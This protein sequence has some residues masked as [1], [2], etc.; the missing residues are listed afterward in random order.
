MMLRPAGVLIISLLFLVTGQFSGSA[1]SAAIDVGNWQAYKAKFI[2]A[3]GRV[4]DDGNHNIS[5][6]EGQGYGLLL[7]YLADQPADFDAIWSFTRTELLIRDD[8]LAAWHWDPSATPHVTDINNAT[9]GDI[10]IAYALTLAGRQWKRDDLTQ[11]ARTIAQSLLDKAIVEHEGRALLLPGVTGF[12]ADDRKDGPVVNPSYCVFEAFPVLNEL[13]PSPKW[14]A[15]S[16][17]CLALLKEMQFGPKQLPAE[18]VSLRDK[19]AP[20]SGFAPEFGY[21]SL[22]IPLYLLRGAIKD[23]ALLTR[24]R[25]GMTD[26]SGSITLVDLPTGTVKTTLNDPGYQFI[27]HLMACVMEGTKIPEPARQFVPT[28]YYPSTLHMLGLALVAEKHPECL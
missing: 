12:S 9:D 13:V 28:L 10:L 3:G 15:V 11:Q 2:D 5:H 17:S 24:L 21:N 25:T 4:I 26:A 16:D 22:R 7:A 14:Q 1:W 23:E 18:W 6:S 8:G 20:A 19:P 27:N